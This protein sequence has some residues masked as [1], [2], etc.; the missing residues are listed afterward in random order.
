MPSDDQKK[1]LW[2]TGIQI[3]GGYNVHDRIELLRELHSKGHKVAILAIKQGNPELFWYREDIDIKFSWNIPIFGLR[4]LSSNLFGAILLC[5]EI[6]FGKWDIIVIQPTWFT[7][8]I[9]P[10]VLLN[11]FLSKT[12]L[13]LDIRT[14]PVYDSEWRAFIEKTRFRLS[15][16]AARTYIDGCTC[17]TKAI[18]QHLIE[19]YNFTVQNWGIW[20]SGVDVDFFDPGERRLAEMNDNNSHSFTIF[21]HGRLDR[22]RGIGILIHAVQILAQQ[23]SDI[24]LV[25]IGSGDFENEIVELSKDKKFKGLINY[26]GIVPYREIPYHIAKADVCVSPLPNFECWRTSSP[27][28]V[29]EYFAMAKVAVLTDIEAH[30]AIGQLPFAKF[31]PPQDPVAMANAIRYFYLNR[32]H[33]TEWGRQARKHIVRNFGWNTVALKFE[34]YILSLFRYTNK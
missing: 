24:K 15:L 5:A 21:Y 12:K 14:L 32:F 29:L 27:L 19:N 2:V 10:F 13:I 26:Y 7:L 4:K 16:E 8:I 33:L 23:L 1:I 28:K 9:S 20:S 34:E 25:F 30:R 3:T 6:L 17:I 31:V 18:Q 22:K 11:W